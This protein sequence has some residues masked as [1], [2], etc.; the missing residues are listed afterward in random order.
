MPDTQV[1]LLAEDNEDD[2]LLIRKSFKLAGVT[3]PVHVV[4]DGEQ[5]IQY[6][7]GEGP[8]AARD[9]FPLPAMLLLDLKMPRMDGFEVLWWVRTKEALSSLI[10]IVLTSSE[11]IGD[12]NKAYELGANSFLVKP[13]DFSNS[14]ELSTLIKHY[15]LLRNKTPEVSRPPRTPTSRPPGRKDQR[16]PE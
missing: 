16:L 6:L 4:R 15:W 13:M 2:V 5:A 12:V 1:I 7:A 11:D 3:N 10:V 9:E 14:A 8:Y